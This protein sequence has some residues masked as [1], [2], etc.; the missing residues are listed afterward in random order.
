[1]KAN[2]LVYASSNCWLTAALRAF[3]MHIKATEFGRRELLDMW[4]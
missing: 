1:M 2:W 3:N 4:C